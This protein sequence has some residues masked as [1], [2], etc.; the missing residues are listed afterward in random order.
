MTLRTVPRGMP[1]AMPPT[2]APTMGAVDPFV[3]IQA[4]CAMLCL[5]ETP[6]HEKLKFAPSIQ[7][8][9]RV[10][11]RANRWLQ[12]EVLAWWAA[13][14]NWQSQAEVAKTI[15]VERTRRKASTVGDT[16]DKQ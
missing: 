10:T 4:V 15:R 7:K 12:S 2:D 16:G 6:I 5:S 11:S 9:M 14:P 3:A 1:P 13:L 8:P